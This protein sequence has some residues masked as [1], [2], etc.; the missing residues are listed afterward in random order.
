MALEMKVA[1]LL[2]Q[3]ELFKASQ[4]PRLSRRAPIVPTLP[5]DEV[6]EIF[7]KNAPLRTSVCRWRLTPLG[8]AVF[9]TYA[10]RSVSLAFQIQKNQQDFCGGAGQGRAKPLHQGPPLPIWAPPQKGAAKGPLGAPGK[11]IS[12]T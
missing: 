5:H 9:A 1:D 2:L 6:L 10:A 7:M 3:P 11:Q 8:Q 4:R 12:R